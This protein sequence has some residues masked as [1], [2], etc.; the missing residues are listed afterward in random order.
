MRT[1]GNNYK[2]FECPRFN[3]YNLCA[4]I[5]ASAFQRNG[6]ENMLVNLQLPLEK[7]SGFD[8][9]SG[10]GKKENQKVQR[11]K[12]PAPRDISNYDDIH[13]ISISQVDTDQHEEKFEVTFA[14]VTKS[15]TCY[16]CGGKWRCSANDPPPPAPYDIIL[17]RK[18]I[19]RYKKRGSTAICLSQKP[20]YVYYHCLESCL[21]RKHDS[22]KKWQS[23][24]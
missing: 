24:G 1:N 4:H 17:R 21:K 12:R 16:G 2:C 14:R 9:V 19:R 23:S 18:E 8:S 13:S 10:A 20:E 22:G 3:E 15:T 7:L 6:L 11:K 5:I